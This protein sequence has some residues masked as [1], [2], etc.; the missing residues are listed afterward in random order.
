M[1]RER[2]TRSTSSG[3]QS[4]P[5]DAFAPT[6]TSSLSQVSTARSLS[7]ALEYESCCSLD[8]RNCEMDRRAWEAGFDNGGGDSFGARLKE[9]LRRRLLLSRSVLL[10]SAD[11]RRARSTSLYRSLLDR[12]PALPAKTSLANPPA[13][14]QRAHRP[15]QRADPSDQRRADERRGVYNGSSIA[16]RNYEGISEINAEYTSPTVHL[17]RPHGTIPVS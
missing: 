4:S 7:P 2:A 11:H 16:Q 5:S 14:P 13:R 17:T 12:P 6:S 10:C 3:R 1:R 15:R 8:S 9:R